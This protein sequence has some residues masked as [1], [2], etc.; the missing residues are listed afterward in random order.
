MVSRALTQSAYTSHGKKGI[1]P[2]PAKGLSSSEQPG[3]QQGLWGSE[4]RSSGPKS[5]PAKGTAMPFQVSSPSPVPDGECIFLQRAV[6]RSN[7]ECQ[8]PEYLINVFFNHMPHS[9]GHTRNM[10]K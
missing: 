3:R 2:D 10:L 5:L 7:Q 6:G 1:N 8:L 4:H 9:P